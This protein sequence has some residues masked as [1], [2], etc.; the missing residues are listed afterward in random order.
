MTAQAAAARDAA[1]HFEAKKT[2]F[3]QAQDGWSLTLRIQHDDVPA[4][5]RD[6]RKGTRYMVVLVEIDDNEEAKKPA[7]I[8]ANGHRADDGIPDFLRR[9]K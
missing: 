2:G 4:H 5:I 3:G 6:S 1:V 8:I 9:A 7:P